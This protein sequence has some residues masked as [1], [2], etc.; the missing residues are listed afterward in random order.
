MSGMKAGKLGVA[1]VDAVG[2]ARL[3]EKLGAVEAGYAVDRATK[4]MERAA[5]L[6][7]GEILQGT[8]EQWIAVFASANAALGAALEMQRRV[9]DR[10]PARPARSPD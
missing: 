5:A 10:S 4:R 2:T 9:A 1:F 3:V 7:G 8:A 6:F